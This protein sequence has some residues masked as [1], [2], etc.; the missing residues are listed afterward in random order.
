MAAL[1]ELF[2]ETRLLVPVSRKGLASGDL[3]LNGHRLQV[4]PLS[5]RNGRGLS[6]KLSFFP[7][8]LW[9]SPT[10]GREL[11][12][13]D[14]VYAPIPGDVGTVG[15]LA[16][17]LLRKPLL[18][19]H[20]GNWLKPVTAAE[21]FWRW[22][23][24]RCAGGRNIMLATGG[25]PEP[26]SKKNPNVHWIFSS[27]VSREELQ[28]YACPRSF[29]GPGPVRLVIVARQEQAKGAGTVIRSLP[30]LLQKMPKIDFEIV[31]DGSAISEFR[32][33]A[34]EA[35]VADRV[36][37]AGKLNHE[38]VML[39]LKAAALFVFPTTSSDGFPKAV[40]EALATGLP[41][42]ATRVSVLPQL[43]GNG[44][45]VLID[46][47]TPEAVARGVEH[48]LADRGTYEAM[49]RKAV[50]TAQQYSLEA[51]RDT[52]GGYLE[53]AWGPLKTND[54]GRT[55]NAAGEIEDA[56]LQNQ[57]GPVVLGP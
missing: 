22:F 35:G 50:E 11:L 37:F 38:Q 49:S 8:L 10:V 9:N 36:N 52:I 31:G 13:S 14:A 16:A 39:R 41:V 1:S 47:A 42:V 54:E 46:E 6:S 28:A 12:L 51:W 17:W 15:M 18:V 53:A 19:R 3:P 33:L 27:S 32:Q 23:M 7:W 21:K 24:E 25:T 2:D 44:S 4:L 45:G 29:P 43:L 30:R 40:L 26:P 57:D 55:L 48:A 20:C 5:V 34:Q 56:R